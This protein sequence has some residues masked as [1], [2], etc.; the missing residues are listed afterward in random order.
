MHIRQGKKTDAPKIARLLLV[1]MEE[2]VY[3]FIGTDDWAQAVDFLEGLVAEPDNQYAYQYVWVLENNEQIVG[4]ALVYDGGRLQQLR[5]PVWKR[6]SE[7]FGRCPEIE[8]ETQE[9][10]YYLDCLAIDLSW[11]GK[12]FGSILIKHLITHFV[13]QEGRVLGL[14]VDQNNPHAKRLYQRLGF[15]VVGEKL[16]MGKR[17]EHMQYRPGLNLQDPE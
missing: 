12:G 8:D 6:L 13:Q 4:A 9:G 1:A 3:R 2:I 16:L 7:R 5:A 11:Q 10:E 15:K 17:H 14:L